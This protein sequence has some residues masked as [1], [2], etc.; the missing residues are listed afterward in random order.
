MPEQNQTEQVEAFSDG[1]FA[2]AMTLLVLKRGEAA[3]VTRQYRFGP[4]LYLVAFG[5]SFLSEGWSVALCL[6]LALFFAL[7]GSPKVSPAARPAR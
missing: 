1:V 6:L 7:H 4:P 5:A 3:Q 2:I